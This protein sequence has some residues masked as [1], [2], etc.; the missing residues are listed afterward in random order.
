VDVLCSNLLKILFHDLEFLQADVQQLLVGHVVDCCTTSIL[1]H[2]LLQT[3]KTLT[4]VVVVRINRACNDFIAEDLIVFHRLVNLGLAAI[5]LLLGNT[6]TF[7]LAIV[8]I[9][10]GGFGSDT[11]FSK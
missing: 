5:D 6:D 11:T 3:V 7:C 1:I 10:N 8:N 2:Q 9:L 4:W